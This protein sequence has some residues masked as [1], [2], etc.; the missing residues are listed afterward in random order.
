MQ[1]EKVVSDGRVP[2]IGQVIRCYRTIAAA[3]RVKTGRPVELSAVYGC[4][5]CFSVG[6]SSARASFQRNAGLFAIARKGC[7][8][9]L[10][11]G[12]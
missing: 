4:W 7:L 10:Q 1:N 2:S 8:S 11:R 5:T 9:G 12:S 6:D 3:E